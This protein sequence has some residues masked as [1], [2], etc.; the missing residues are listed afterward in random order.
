[1]QHI[2]ALPRWRWQQQQESAEGE[3]DQ[4]HLRNRSCTPILALRKHSGPSQVPVL[5]T[6]G[7][8]GE[9][10]FLWFFVSWKSEFI[11]DAQ[12]IFL[13][14]FS[15]IYLVLNISKRQSSAKK[16]INQGN[17]SPWRVAEPGRG[18]Q[19]IPHSDTRPRLKSAAALQGLHFH[20]SQTFT[21]T[22]ASKTNPVP[23]VYIFW[24]SS[25]HRSC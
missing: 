24:M 25:T 2:R 18:C 16:I 11:P 4:L 1:M 13:L 14:W 20:S 15:L 9:M 10:P 5:G 3:R 12:Q 21:A 8:P 22:Q 6:G 17:L 23:S 7:R 19:V